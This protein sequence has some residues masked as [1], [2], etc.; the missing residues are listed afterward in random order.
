LSLTNLDIYPDLHRKLLDV[1][2]K[3]RGRG[4]A[5]ESLVVRSC[6]VYSGEWE[7]E[8][9]ELVGRVTWDYVTVIVSRDGG[10][11]ESEEGIDA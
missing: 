8:L 10:V 5:L 3:R 9:R 2:R 6:R 7:E 11:A 1:L 4:I